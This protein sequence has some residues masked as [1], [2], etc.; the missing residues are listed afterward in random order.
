MLIS[1]NKVHGVRAKPA[2][3]KQLF[4]CQQL[5]VAKEAPTQ[6]KYQLIKEQ[7]FNMLKN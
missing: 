5:R 3:G 2:N 1:D 4:V 7:A 6:A